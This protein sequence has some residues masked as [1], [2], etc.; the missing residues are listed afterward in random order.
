[1]SGNLNQYIYIFDSLD[2]VIRSAVTWNIG[3]E[4]TESRVLYVFNRGLLGASG[5]IFYKVRIP[6][7]G[8]VQKA[9]NHT[10]SVWE[11]LLLS[12]SFR[13]G[14]K[15]EEPGEVVRGQATRLH[16]IGGQGAKLATDGRC[17]ACIALRFLLLE[18]Q[19]LEIGI[20]K[21]SRFLT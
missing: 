16:F 3:K 10:D 15:G 19:C 21:Q 11:P 2:A 13:A 6:E 20:V 7:R 14:G 8:A 17:V 1:M 4:L 5:M 18:L 12:D 9:G